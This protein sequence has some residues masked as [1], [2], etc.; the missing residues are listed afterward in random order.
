MTWKGRQASIH[1]FF[2]LILLA[3]T[4]CHSSSVPLQKATPAPSERVLAFHDPIPPPAST[5]QVV[6]DTGVGIPGC[7]FEIYVN[8]TLAARIDK[9][10]HVTFYLS[11]GP[12]LLQ[13]G[14][15]L[16]GKVLC[17]YDP[18]NA[19]Q[20]KTT[21]RPNEEQVFR[22]S[23]SAVGKIHLSRENGDS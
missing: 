23:S 16:E 4:A 5:I 6:R 17:G 3:F 7:Y 13:V 14:P 9:G 12:L 8:Q 11:P 18:G 20:I 2:I 10:E 21:L 15:D 19:T 22:I 1:S